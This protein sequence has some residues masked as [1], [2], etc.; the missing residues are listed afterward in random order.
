MRTYLEE[1]SSEEEGVHGVGDVLLEEARGNH[2]TLAIEVLQDGPEDPDED[3]A[4]AETNDSLVRPGVLDAAILDEEGVGD[5]TAHGERDT[6]GVHLQDALL[7]SRLDGDGGARGREEQE[8]EGTG[9]GTDGKVDVEAPTPADVVGEGAADQ[10]T[11]DAGETVGGADDTGEG[12]AAGRG[13]REGDDGVG[14]GTQT[15]AT[16]TGDGAADDEGFGVGGGT[17][18]GGTDLE[19]EEGHEEGPLEV[20]E[21]VDLTP[22]GRC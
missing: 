13:R 18:D 22:C 7:P 19:D 11:D 4:D 3:P 9:D 5:D 14:S 17:A 20:E 21:L 2:R 10:G 6:G 16:E 15:G 12:R 8:D 1:S